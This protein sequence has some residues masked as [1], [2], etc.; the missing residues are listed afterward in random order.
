MFVIAAQVVDAELLN[1]LILLMVASTVL[2]FVTPR[3]MITSMNALYT[4]MSIGKFRAQVRRGLPSYLTEEEQ[5]RWL[6]RAYLLNKSKSKLPRLKGPLPATLP[7][8]A[9]FTLETDPLHFVQSTWGPSK[10]AKASSSGY[11]SGGSYYDSG[12]GYDGGGGS[13]GGGAGA[14]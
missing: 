2:Y 8:A 11:D 7:L 9:L 12:G 13:D 1:M 5:E 14:D 3:S 10:V 6:T 4:K